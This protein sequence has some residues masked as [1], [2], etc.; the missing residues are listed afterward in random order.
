M[1]EP[2][3]RAAAAAGIALDVAS[4]RALA[5]S[6]D[7]A[8]RGD[9]PY[10]NTLVRIMATRCMTQVWRGRG[11]FAFPEGGGFSLLA[12]GVGAGREGGQKQGRS[13]RCTHGK[14]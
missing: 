11:L 1:F 3:L 4:S 9:D 5:G 14:S 8:V 13:G 2:L 6:L 12:F 7:G 10:F